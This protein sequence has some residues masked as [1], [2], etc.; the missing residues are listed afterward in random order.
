MVV[1][2]EITRDEAEQLW[3]MRQ[4]GVAPRMQLSTILNHS[5]DRGLGKWDIYNINV[6][7][8]YHDFT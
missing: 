3:E 7:K 8:Q 1:K 2:K 4:A 5:E 6:K